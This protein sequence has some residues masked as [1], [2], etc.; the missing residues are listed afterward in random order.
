MGKKTIYAY[1][2]ASARAMD[3]YKIGE[4]TNGGLYRTKQQD[5]SACCEELEFLGEFDAEG[6][7][8]KEF[9]LFLKESGIQNERKEWFKVPGGWAMIQTHWAAFLHKNRPEPLA[10]EIDVWLAEQRKMISSGQEFPAPADGGMTAAR[11]IAAVN[12][13]LR[14]GEKVDQVLERALDAQDGMFDLVRRTLHS[15]RIDIS[16]T[17]T[18]VHEVAKDI[19][20][21]RSMLTATRRWR[22]YSLVITI[23]AVCGIAATN[24][25]HVTARE[26]ALQE[27]FLEVRRYI[28][29]EYQYKFK[30]LQCK[31]LGR[32]PMP[33]LSHRPPEDQERL[34]SSFHELE[35]RVVLDLAHHLAL[36][37]GPA[38]EAIGEYNRQHPHEAGPDL[39]T[40]W[41]YS[42][43]P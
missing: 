20:N 29:G 7:G 1:T 2:T 43:C 15:D 10:H 40:A 19:A 31:A 34:R 41:A 39:L 38:Y 25:H 16:R 13:L 26:A 3:L 11:H 37:P 17:A 4:T 22:L 24:S 12:T 27:R 21:L 5:N 9:H 42:P 28:L 8:D 35:R 14:T 23:I 33:S 6:F 32:D 18:A 36:P 30:E